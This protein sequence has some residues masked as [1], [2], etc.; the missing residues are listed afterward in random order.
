MRERIPAHARPETRVAQYLRGPPGRRDAQ[1]VG[2]LDPVLAGSRGIDPRARSSA[3]SRRGRTGFR[4]PDV[5]PQSGIRRRLHRVHER[6]PRAARPSSSPQAAGSRAGGSTSSIPAARTIPPRPTRPPSEMVGCFAVDDA[7]Q[8][9]PNSFQ[10]NK[11]HAWFDP[12][13]ASRTSC[14]IAGSTTGCTRAPGP[15]QA[16][17]RSSDEGLSG[18]A[19]A[20]PARR[21]GLQEQDPLAA[22]DDAPLPRGAYARRGSTWRSRT[23][24]TRTSPSTSPCDLVGLTCMSHQASRAYQI[25]DEFRRRGRPVVIGGLPRHARA[26]RGAATR[27]RRGGGR[28]RGGLG[29]GARGRGVRPL[30]GPLRQH[31]A[32]R[33]EGPARPPATTCST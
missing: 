11:N 22:G 5:P 24:C 32:L 3:R 17:R 16:C 6:E 30:A 9:V 1:L 2:F 12:E 33:P 18:P 19:L 13:T 25:A 15:E 23:T 31:E 7:G 29:P 27:R 4:P 14:P 8:I 26:R 21:L 10:Y 28:G 20:T